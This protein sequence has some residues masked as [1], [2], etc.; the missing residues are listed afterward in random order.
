MNRQLTKGEGQM[1]ASIFKM[2]QTRG[3]AGK[4][5]GTQARLSTEKS[6]PAEGSTG[7]G[8]PRWPLPRGAGETVPPLVE[9]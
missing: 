5:T 7:P 8:C 2:Q 4:N 1:F 9:A 6:F 3:L